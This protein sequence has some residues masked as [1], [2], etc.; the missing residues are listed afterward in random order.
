MRAIR[1]ISSAADVLRRAEALDALD[2]VLPFDR[3]EFLAE[4][5][6]DDDVE[7]LRHLAREGIGENSMRALASDLA[8][9]EAWCQAATANPLP[10]PAPE[11]LL[12]KF[13]AHH[14]WDPARRETDPAHGMPDDVSV[15]LTQAGLLRS[16]GPHSPSTVRRR[17]SSW[18]TLTQWRGLQGKFN[19]PRL[20]N[21][22]KLAVRASSRPRHRKSA[23]AVTVDV[24]SALLKACAG[25]RLVD[26]RDRALLMVAFASGGRRRSEVSSLRIDQLVEQ[27]PVPADPDNSDTASLACLSIHLGRTKTTEADDGASVLLIGKPV[28]A[29]KDWLARAAITEGAVFRRIDRWG[30]LER[31]PLTPQAVN[32]ILKRRILQAGLD[33]RE[34]SAHGLR[35][36]FL[37]EAARR[38]IPL[39]EAMQQSQHRSVQQASRY[40]NDAER[41]HGKAARLIV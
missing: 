28:S 30:H 18:S 29:L 27:D 22:T 35:A 34:F 17:L 13:L 37:T 9:L 39:P 1:T 26:V 4:L 11:A 15:A 12:L 21:A 23:K 10:W 8:Y 19:A 38:G 3:R 16:S 36:G 41:R 2:A 25:N 20:L 5:L 6:S 32:L 24:L 31:R 40:Y 33:P 7:T 14:L